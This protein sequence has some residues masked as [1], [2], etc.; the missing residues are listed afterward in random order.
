MVK[1]K[2]EAVNNWRLLE[3]MSALGHVWTALGKNFL[4]FC[5][6]GRVR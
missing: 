2:F 4:T 6:I 1:P 5:S 3:A